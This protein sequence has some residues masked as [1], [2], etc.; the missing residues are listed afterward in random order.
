MGTKNL[1]IAS[2]MIEDQGEVG[3][4]E[5]ETD[6]TIRKVAEVEST[7]GDKIET[8]PITRARN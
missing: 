4:A 1:S 6:L 5:E 7:Q 2:E 3:D 8:S